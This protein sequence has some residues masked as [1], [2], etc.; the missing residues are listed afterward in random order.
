MWVSFYPFT[1]S[2]LFLV[3]FFISGHQSCP[4]PPTCLFPSRA[5]LVLLPL[6][7]SIPTPRLAPPSL[8]T[9][10]K[11]LFPVLAWITDTH[12]QHF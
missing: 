9:V 5:T 2:V 4:D 11:E 10:I 6:P 12:M 1:P 8:P 7:A 3:L